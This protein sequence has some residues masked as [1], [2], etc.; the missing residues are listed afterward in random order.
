MQEV[1]VEYLPAHV[2][3]HWSF[4]TVQKAGGHDEVLYV[5]H[6]SIHGTRPPTASHVGS[7]AHAAGSLP[8][9]AEQLILQ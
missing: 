8:Y 6:R 1:C 9:A 4:S 2:V 3:R 7:R 5:L